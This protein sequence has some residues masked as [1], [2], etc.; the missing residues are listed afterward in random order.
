MN[1]QKKL[2]AKIFVIKNNYKT[3]QLIN[4]I[5]QRNKLL[6]KIITYELIPVNEKNK[7]SLLLKGVNN[8]P[9]LLINGSV[10]VGLDN[11][12]KCQIRPIVLVSLTAL[13]L[14]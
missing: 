5:N 4:F 3:K 8:F 1:T 2:K 9:S 11:S 14:I 10:Y 7:K 6:C 13:K 12:A